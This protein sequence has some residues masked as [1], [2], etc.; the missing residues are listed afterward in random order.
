LR[1][2]KAGLSGEVMEA[3]EGP[4]WRLTPF[5]EVMRDLETRFPVFGSKEIE[6]IYPL[7][8]ND[9]NLKFKKDYN[10]RRKFSNWSKC[11]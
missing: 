2:F 9:D 1:A 10:R 5:G 4:F 7:K 6:N 11:I 8:F 3:F